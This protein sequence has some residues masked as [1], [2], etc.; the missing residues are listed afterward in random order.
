MRLAQNLFEWGLITYHR[1]DSTR[2][3]DKGIDVAR[4]WISQAFPGIAERVFRPRRW[5]EGGAHEAIRPTRPIDADT[6]QR[7]VE[8]GVL[9]IAGAMTRAHY[10][11]Y[12][13]I[14]RRFMA[15]QMAPAKAR[16][17]RYRVRLVEFNLEV[18]VERIVAIGDPGD[19]ASRGF[20]LV[21]PYVREQPPLPTGRVWARVYYG[22]A[23]K[24]PL[25]TQGDVIKLMKERGIGR[26]ST[27]AKIVETLFKRRYVAR[28]GQDGERIKSTRRGE[29]VHEY[30]TVYLAEAPE[31]GLPEGLDPGALRRV[32]A[33]VSEER[34]RQ[35]QE[36]MD[37]IEE[38]RAERRSVLDQVFAEVSG[39]AVPLAR[40]MRGECRVFEECLRGWR[41]RG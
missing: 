39:V 5:G 20:T 23:P 29:A 26:P 2:V 15:S 6:L 7:L 34:T 13:L 24:V 10:R 4:Q 22:E 9:E 3:S 11:L 33:L 35:L 36:L 12:D 27:Y 28:V 30:L 31:E 21:W 40:A 16:K 17:H 14:F 8:E 25:Y 19:P 38:G 37:L 32:P 18:P 41:R 1:T